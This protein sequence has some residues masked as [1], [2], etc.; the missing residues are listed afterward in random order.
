M[1]AIKIEKDPSTGEDL[2]KEVIHL[3]ASRSL[4]GDIMIFDHEDV[5][6]VVIPTKNKC[7]AFPK[8]EIDDKA[9]G[10]QD[11]LFNVLASRGVIDPS[12]I[13]GGSFYGAMEAS[14]LKSSFEGIDEVQAALYVIHKFLEEE[15]PYFQATKSISDRDLDH[16]LDPEDE[17]STEL[18]DVPHSDKKG[19]MDP[20]VRPYGYM[21]NYSLI[22]EDTDE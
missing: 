15:K 6:I 19:S 14:I 22:R 11:R 7:V 12:S 20:Q 21:Y 13:R 1:I 10:A 5:D 18:G 17:Y 8:E 9:Y 2:P 4:S 16:V 3:N